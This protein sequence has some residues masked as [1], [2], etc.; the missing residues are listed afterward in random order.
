MELI[1]DIIVIQEGAVNWGIS[2][3]AIIFSRKGE[4]RMTKREQVMNF[5]A[6]K[7]DMCIANDTIADELFTEYEIGRAHV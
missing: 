6:E 5:A 3:P 2:S 1:S 4:W 7:K